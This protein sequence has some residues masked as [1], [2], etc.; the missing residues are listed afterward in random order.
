[1]L[2]FFGLGQNVDIKIVLNDEDVRRKEEIRTD[3][4]HVYSL[5]VF[6]DGETVSGSILIGMKRGNKLEHQGIRIDFLGIIEFYTDRGSRS[7]FLTLSQDLARPGIL[8]QPTSYPFEFANIQMAHESYSGTNVRL[9]YFLRVTVQRRLT[10]MSKERD[11]LVH[12][13]AKSSEP[14]SGIQMQVG[15]EDSLHI[16]FEYNKSRYHLQDVIVGKIYF[17]L[18]R[19][20]IKNMEIQILKRETLGSGPNMFS[21]SETLAK[22]EIMDGAPVRGESIPIR[23]FLHGYALTPT[24]RDVNRKFSVRYF[25]N[26]VLLDEEDRRYY[27]QQEIILYRKPDRH[28]KLRGPLNTEPTPPVLNA[29]SEVPADSP[30]AGEAPVKEPT[31]GDEE[32]SEKTLSSELD[33]TTQSDITDNGTA[34][35]GNELSQPSDSADRQNNE[36]TDSCESSPH[37]SRNARSMHRYEPKHIPKM[38]NE[39]DEAPT[40]EDRQKSLSS[41][42]TEEAPVTPTYGEAKNLSEQTAKQTEDMEEKVKHNSPNESEDKQLP[43]LEGETTRDEENS[44]QNETEDK[45]TSD[46]RLSTPIDA[47]SAETKE[48]HS[49]ISDAKG[50][51]ETK[52]KVSPKPNEAEDVNLS[53]SQESAVQQ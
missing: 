7:E 4:G 36:E 8:S 18:V 29:D 41:F 49:T 45:Q 43:L 22:Y 16:E 6:Y 35:S 11:I 25:L 53:S 12:S 3:D 2:N 33:T 44:P 34:A 10:D 40:S 24:M 1:M 31:H 48:T 30:Q 19:V 47:G 15:I 42:K 50:D 23:L 32:K 14:D 5:P 27:K 28:R 52:D 26:L 39:P 46:I 37:T 9:R 17:L 38:L 13:L 51:N 20:K 21:D